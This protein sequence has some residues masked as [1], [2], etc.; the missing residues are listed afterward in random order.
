MSN[1][2]KVLA[3][4]RV[5]GVVVHA[6]SR[7]GRVEHGTGV[8]VLVAREGVTSLLHVR[9]LGVG[10]GSGSGRLEV[11]DPRSEKRLVTTHVGL[12]GQHV[13]A[14]LEVGLLGVW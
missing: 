3:V 2:L 7:L 10:L 4:V 9:L 8:L 14:L 13:L 5:D 12:A 11:S 6:E 1:G